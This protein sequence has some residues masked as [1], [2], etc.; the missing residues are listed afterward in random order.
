[1]NDAPRPNSG[2]GFPS[3]REEI[4]AAYLAAG[5]CLPRWVLPSADEFPAEPTSQKQ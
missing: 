3:T 4:R 5:G 1:M 2:F